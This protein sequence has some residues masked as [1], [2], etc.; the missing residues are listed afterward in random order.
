MGISIAASTY[1]QVFKRELMPLNQLI[2]V[3]RLLADRPDAELRRHCL[4][5]IR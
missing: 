2:I 1:Q 5:W 4:F 3:R